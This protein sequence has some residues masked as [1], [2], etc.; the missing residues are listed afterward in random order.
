[1][2]VTI[3]EIAKIAGVCRAT[4]DK[5]IHNRPGVKEKTRRRVQQV[6]ADLDYKPNIAGRALKFQQKKLTI[7]VIMVQVDASPHIMGGIQ[8]QVESV[9]NFGFDIETHSVP[10]PDAKA[11][12]QI[13]RECSQRDIAGV[14]LNPLNDPRVISAI[15]EL[16]KKEIPVIT[17][18]S[19]VPDSARTCFIGQNWIQAGRTAAHLMAKFLSGA[20]TVA[21]V[22]GSQE[23]LCPLYRLKGFSEHLR[24]NY[25]DIN[26]FKVL[27]T[28]ENALLTYQKTAEMLHEHPDINGIFITSG[29]VKEV[30]RAV[31]ALGFAGRVSIVCFDLYDDIRELIHE[32]VIDCTIGQDLHKQGAYPIQLFFQRLYH[33]QPLPNGEIFTP[34]DIRIAE[35]I[36]YPANC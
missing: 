16:A 5:V 31:S 6:I 30:G 28:R 8:E 9:K 29:C 19:D 25:P 26:L 14:I 2:P 15:N 35:N 12:A 13:L 18:N 4:V 20:G 21:V 32:G 17:V 7:V 33:N 34:I 10:Y 23:L 11:Q 22:T 3:K 27:E 36:D 24:Q 1:M